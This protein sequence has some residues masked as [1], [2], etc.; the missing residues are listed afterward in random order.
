MRKKSA[1][2]SETTVGMRSI[3]DC[4]RRLVLVDEEQ[5]DHRIS[6]FS[7]RRFWLSERSSKTMAGHDKASSLK[8]DAAASSSSVAIDEAPKRRIAHQTRYD[9][10]KIGATTRIR[11]TVGCNGRSDPV[12]LRDSLRGIRVLCAAEQISTSAGNRTVAE[13][14]GHP[15]IRSFGLLFGHSLIRSV[16]YNSVI[17][18]A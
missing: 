6:H 10:K 12:W 7:L 8:L 5:R 18:S 4:C 11:R 16:H 15:L 13:E 1:S 9:R 17:R 2:T 14:F 3:V